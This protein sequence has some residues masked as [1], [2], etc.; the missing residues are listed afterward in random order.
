MDGQRLVGAS[1][2]P[3]KQSGAEAVSMAKL[4][5]LLTGSIFEQSFR[6]GDKFPTVRIDKSEATYLYSDG[7]HHHFMDTRTYDQVPVDEDMLESV[8]PLLK[9]GSIAH[10]LRYQ[11][12]LIGVELPINV[13]LKVVKTDPGFRGDT[14]SGGTKPATLETG[15][16]IQVPLFIQ[17]GDVIR[18]D[19]RTQTYMERA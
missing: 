10:L 4:R 18:V 16:V 5:N 17:S 8:L 19:T 7:T 1:Y 9:E 12:K 11:G 3:I 6:S 2:G 13:E 15:A 14:V